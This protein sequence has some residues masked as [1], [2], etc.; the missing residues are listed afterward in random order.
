MLQ[1]GCLNWWNYEMQFLYFNLMR[2]FLD[3]LFFSFVIIVSTWTLSKTYHF[4]FLILQRW[5]VQKSVHYVCSSDA[6]YCV[7]MYLH[8][9][10][11]ITIMYIS[12]QK[13]LQQCCAFTRITHWRTREI[14]S[15]LVSSFYVCKSE[16]WFTSLYRALL[17]YLF[18]H[19]FFLAVQYNPLWNT[20]LP[21]AFFVALTWPLYFLLTT[22]TLIL[23]LLCS[24]VS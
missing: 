4:P 19:L 11:F 22:F 20:V 23:S 5:T 1:W 12:C 13:C 2:C 6:W 14:I 17:K 8:N 15:S 7:K 9:S 16:V 21:F 3:I 24:E 10:V 18:N